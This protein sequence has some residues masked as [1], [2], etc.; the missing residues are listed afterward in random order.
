MIDS[1]RFGQIVIDG[2]VYRSD[3]ILFPD[4][5]DAGW[6]R[7]KGHELAVADLAD[8]LADPPEVLV[9]GTG[10]YGRMAIL[11]ETEQAL[12]AQNVQ[13]IAQP[14]RTAC[15]TVNDMLATGRRVVAALHLT[16]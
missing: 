3:I 11:Q 12:A 10:C 9:V 5:V 1:Y 8:V 14:T 6:W 15:Q 4:R 7:V 13:L 2:Q 16:C